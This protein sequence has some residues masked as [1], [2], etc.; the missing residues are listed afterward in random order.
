MHTDRRGSLSFIDRYW[1]TG[2]ECILFLAVQ[3]HK[4]ENTR[5]IFSSQVEKACKDIWALSFSYCDNNLNTSSMSNIYAILSVLPLYS[6]ALTQETDVM[7]NRR[8]PLF[9][10]LMAL[11]FSGPGKKTGEVHW[12]KFVPKRPTEQYYFDMVDIALNTFLRLLTFEQ[13]WPFARS[14]RIKPNRHGL[15]GLRD[16]PFHQFYMKCS[17]PISPFKIIISCKRQFSKRRATP[18]RIYPLS[19]ILWADIGFN[20]SL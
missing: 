7:Y 15:L 10:N 12:I 8:L 6:K 13:K 20:D 5:Y 1:K 16:I 2:S 11:A 14:A 3:P 17:F 4:A 9:S 18:N 19:T